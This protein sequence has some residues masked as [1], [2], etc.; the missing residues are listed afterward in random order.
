MT[1]ATT[2]LCLAL[3]QLQPTSVE[4]IADVRDAWRRPVHIDRVEQAI[5][6]DAVSSL[7]WQDTAVDDAGAFDIPDNG[8]ARVTFTGS[9]AEPALLK[10][11][12][13]GDVW[14]NGLP[15]GGD[16]YG[17]GL[18][19]PFAMREGD[20]EVLL[21]RGRG[22]P[23]PVVWTAAQLNDAHP[24]AASR[25]ARVAPH[26]STLP[27]ALA[28]EPLEAWAGII[29][30]NING[31]PLSGASISARVG[32]TAVRT[33]VPT[34]PPYAFLKVPVRLSAAAT[35]ST[36][37]RT[38]HLTLS[39]GGTVLDEA[40]LKL[41]TRLRTDAYKRTFVSDIDG[42]VQYYCMREAL[43][44]GEAAPG[45]VLS[46]HG[47]SVEATSQARCFKNRDWCHII[48]PTNRRP[49][50][51]D[52]EDWGRLDAMEVL[53]DARSHYANDADRTWL[54]GHSM[55]GHGTW[56]VG[57]TLPDQWAAIAPSAGWATFWS[58]TG[59]DRYPEDDGV[60]EMLHRAANPSDTM[61][62]LP[63]AERFGVYI[64]HG[65]ADKVVPVREARDM[66]R[67]LSSFHPN[68][69]YFEEPDAGHW[70][71]DRCMDFPDLMHF[72]QRHQ[73]GVGGRRDRLR[74]VTV[75]P[76]ASS[77]CDWIG[78]LQQE[79]SLV[80]SS[81]DLR[82]EQ[83]DEATSITG[84]TQNITALSIDPSHADVQA[85]GLLRITLDGKAP[86][87][88]M[89]DGSTVNLHRD[90][91][92]G[93]HAS[94]PPSPDTKNPTRAGR[95]RSAWNHDVILIY[96]TTGTPQ[97]N[98]WS[99]ARA[100]QDAERWWYRG[101]GKVELVADSDFNP[102]AEPDRGVIVYGNRDVN[103]AWATLLADAPLQ[104]NRVAVMTPTST[105][106]DDNLALVQVRPRPGS[107]VASVAVIA[108]TG[109][110]GQRLTAT[111]P[112]FLAGVGW[113]DW[114]VVHSNALLY[115]EDGVLGAGFFGADWSMDPS[116]SRWKTSLESLPRL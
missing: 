14:I 21:R 3:A 6:E 105:M 17:N 54:T 96:G 32:D 108:G 27:D 90:A 109:R 28:N 37:D 56:N 83:S 67:A 66:R 52:W 110:A 75:D 19:L 64:L 72:L 111:M 20:N 4:T 45:I 95:L 44:G 48:A 93:W 46:L 87:D 70:W 68:F 55:G 88:V 34:V 8:W 116:Q 12:A 11:H 53:A 104:V 33:D 112:L 77:T 40:A 26:D 57:L 74:F 24:H 43:P 30:Q 16:I 18:E 41:R 42:S 114:M 29:V 59:P 35:S 31:T 50:G 101:N 92:G 1:T 86:V 115:G 78:V 15:R 71:G 25:I 91:S 94:S 7:P 9:Q 99:Y 76:S 97:E 51:F 10:V 2:L 98:A 81:V 38:L 85:D 103:S 79:Q 39:H 73:L 13:V 61:L 80:P 49:F 82:I 69:A 47:A 63:N 100:R 5:A 60:L 65:D 22:R 102:D 23:A 107:D 36:D 106:H 62:M 58:Y 89:V 113:P 84:D